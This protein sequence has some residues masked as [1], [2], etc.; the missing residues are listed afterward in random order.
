M[1]KRFGHNLCEFF[2]WATSLATPVD[3]S[4]HYCGRFPILASGH[5]KLQG[6][7]NTFANIVDTT[8]S[9]PPLCLTAFVITSTASGEINA[10]GKA[11]GYHAEIAANGEARIT[12]GAALTQNANG[13]YEA[14]VQRWDGAKMDW[15]DKKNISTFFPPSWSEARITYE[16]T[17][18][19]KIKIPDP[20]G[21]WTSTTPSGIEIRLFWDP[22]NQRTTFYPTGKS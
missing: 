18:A 16:V 17:E 1:A 3:V 10:S 6:A 13:T 15:I 8:L 7:P 20:R 4:I 14:P 2:C 22:K 12:P 5:L 11:T 9:T 21:G 19:F